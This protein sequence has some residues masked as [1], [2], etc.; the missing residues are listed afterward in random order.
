[1]GRGTTVR[2]VIVFPQEPDRVTES[3]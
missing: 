1:V 2:S 3:Q